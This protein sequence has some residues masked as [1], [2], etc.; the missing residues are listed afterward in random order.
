[1][2]EA[3]SYKTNPFDHQDKEFT[4]H[5]TDVAR[6]FLWEMGTG[7]SKVNVDESGYL[8]EQGKIDAMLIVAPGGVHGNWIINELPTHLPDRYHG[9]DA[10]AHLQHEEGQATRAINS[11]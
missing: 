2:I 4:E 11:R 9:S 5:G 7:K 6:G 3:Y 1:M 10:D 8:F